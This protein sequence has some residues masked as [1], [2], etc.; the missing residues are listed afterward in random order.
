MYI[1]HVCKFV[2]EQGMNETRHISLFIVEDEIIIAMHME[3]VL[4][5]AGYDVV[6]KVSTGEEAVREVVNLKP[7]FVLMDIQLAGR[8]KELV[9]IPVIFMTGFP[10]PQQKERVRKISPTA[11]LLKPVNIKSLLQIIESTPV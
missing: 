3:S 1:H 4:K 2:R 7:S 11:Y 6:K 8:I 10:N 9:D 5:K